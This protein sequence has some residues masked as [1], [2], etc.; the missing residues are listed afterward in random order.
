MIPKVLRVYSGDLTFV[1]FWWDPIG[2][3]KFQQ[4]E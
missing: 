4:A 3:P 1:T 2:N